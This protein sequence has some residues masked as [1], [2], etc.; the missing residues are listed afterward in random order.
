M[1]RA[2]PERLAALV[3]RAYRATAGNGPAASESRE[4]Q[5]EGAAR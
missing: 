3:G 5:E 4:R 1:D 2:E